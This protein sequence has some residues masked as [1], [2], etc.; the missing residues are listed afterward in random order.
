MEHTDDQTACAFVTHPLKRIVPRHA[1]VHLDWADGDRRLASSPRF[2]ER[3]PLSGD[4]KHQIQWARGVCCH[5]GC[6]M[7]QAYRIDTTWL[8]EHSTSL[9][10]FPA[11]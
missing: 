2:A 6:L 4:R 3:G 9:V 5:H 1:A 7:L 8:W 11:I 10:R